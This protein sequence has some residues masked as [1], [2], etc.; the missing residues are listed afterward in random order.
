MSRNTVFAPD[1]FY[2]IYNRGTEKRTIFLTKLDYERF[3]ALLYLCNSTEAVR[4]SDHQKSTLSERL[5]LERSKL[6]VNVCVYCL[7]PNHFH[8]IIQEKKE[9]GISRF[10]QKLTTG[11][12]MY[13]NKLNER[14]GSLFQGRFKA[15]HAEEDRYLKYL[16]A[17]IHLNPIKIIDSKWK[18]N[19]I[20][21]KD[22]TERFLEQYPYSSFL[23]Y[24]EKDR[25][26][27]KIITK[28]AL[29]KYFNSINDFRS[30]IRA[31]LNFRDF[32][33]NAKPKAKRQ[34]SRGS[35]GSTS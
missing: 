9:N 8:L 34:V 14:T 20:K 35:R 30:T 2:H 29:P 18:E 4:L 27:G 32:E 11:Y 6:L 23:D 3:L 21:N 31:W 24:C 1:E 10:M 25:L 15:T 16:I 22:Q 19:G 5:M 33:F 12:T 17:Y 26:E 7:M 28:D 13:F